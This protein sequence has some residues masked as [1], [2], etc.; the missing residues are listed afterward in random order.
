MS[1]DGG[2]IAPNRKIVKEDSNGV[3]LKNSFQDG[4]QQPP[5]NPKDHSSSAGS[6][7]IV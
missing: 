1:E 7:G 3:S 2:A 6:I 4:Q 5:T